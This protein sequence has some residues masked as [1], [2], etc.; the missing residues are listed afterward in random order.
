MMALAKDVLERELKASEAALKAHQE[1]IEVHK[2]VSEAFQK[3]LEKC[4]K[5]K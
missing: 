4:K 2:I 1:G 3:E 5:N